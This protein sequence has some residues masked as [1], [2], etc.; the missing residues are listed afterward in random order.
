MAPQSAGVMGF[1]RLHFQLPSS[2]QGRRCR[3]RGRASSRH[4]GASRRPVPFERRPRM[5]SACP[6]RRR[7]ARPSPA[8]ATSPA[9]FRP[10]VAS[11]ISP[12]TCC[13]ARPSTTAAAARAIGVNDFNTI[14]NSGRLAAGSASTGI[15]AGVNN[16]ITNTAAGVI[17]VVDNGI[18]NLRRR[19]QHRDERRRNHHRRHG[20]ARRRGI[21]CHQRQ[22]HDRQ[23]RAVQ[24]STSATLPPASD[25]GR[26]C[27]TVTNA[28]AINVGFSADIVCSATLRRRLS[29]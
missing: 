3:T 13:P 22:Q 15:F 7:A 11:T 27:V 12:S 4:V 26:S 14:I 19:Q 23:L 18:G 6:I 25:A 10:A 1:R 24:P 20:R 17:A 21:F 2:V 16:T 8:A 29:Y 28:G 5:R 9:V